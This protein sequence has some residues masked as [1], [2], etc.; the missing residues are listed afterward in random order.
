VV[1]VMVI[2]IVLGMVMVMVAVMTILSKLYQCYPLIRHIL[3]HKIGKVE[4]KR[5]GIKVGNGG[6]EC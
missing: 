2:L 5:G 1:L 6:R 4:E 3:L